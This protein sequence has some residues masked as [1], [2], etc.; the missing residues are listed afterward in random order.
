VVVGKRT[1]LLLRSGSSKE[2]RKLLH[3]TG[4]HDELEAAIAAVQA[5]HSQDRY[6]ETL[7]LLE[8]LAEKHHQVVE[9]VFLLGAAFERSGETTRAATAF[10]QALAVDPDHAPTLNYLGYMWAD[11]GERLDHALALVERAVS[12]EPNNGAYV[13]SL[14]WVLYRL[15][16]FGEARE[17]LERA[18]RLVPGDPVI[19]EHLGDVYVALGDRQKAADSYRR[20]LDRADEGSDL[21]PHEVRRKLDRLGDR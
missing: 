20:A 2:A 19:F 12:L 16:R 14:G 13:D 18:A 5:F 1:E 11:R 10:E 4:L 6:A 21:D 7:P 8:K 3:D 15:G 17:H 9:P